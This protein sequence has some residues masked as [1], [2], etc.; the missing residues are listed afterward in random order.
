[1][2]INFPY[3]HILATF[4][5]ATGMACVSAKAP[6]ADTP[7][8]SRLLFSLAGS[9]TIGEHLAPAWVEAFLAAKSATGIYR[10]PMAGANEYR[11]HGT[12]EYEKVH[13]DIRA[14]GSS[15]GFK[16]LKNHS[17]DIAMSSRGIKQDELVSLAALGDL[18]TAA[19]E[20]VVAIDGLAVIV[21]PQN[22]IAALSMDSLA[23][24]FSG[25][26]THW[27]Q[28]GGSDHAISVHARDHNS[29]TWDTFK[30]LVLGENNRLA[31]GAARYESNDELSASVAN[32]VGAIG[33]VGL[34]SVNKSKALAIF[35]GDTD[36]LPPLPLHVATED[37]LLARRLFLY[38]STKPTG[39]VQEF[40]HFCQTHDGQ[41]LVE[42]IGFV[43]QNPLRQVVK[44]T[45]GPAFYREMSRRAERLSINFRFQRNS[46]ELDNKAKRDVQRLAH[47]LKQP[48]NQDLRVQ[49]IGFSDERN[50]SSLAEVLS[51]LRATVVK[52]E[53]F[54]HGIATEAVVGFGA[55]RPVAQASGTKSKNDR[56]EV[57]VYADDQDPALRA[58]RRR[59]ANPDGYLGAQHTLAR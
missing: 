3:F 51:R 53:L 23:L 49:L 6:H 39:L 25:K 12:F 4:I 29:G 33:F 9:N 47:F 35:D 41:E 46:A 26:I 59:T 36:A 20:H 22:P 15:T 28:L 57:W 44:N 38:T 42:E 40:V 54:H 30:T 11:V 8:N 10:E 18:S 37:Y 13:I 56:V 1:M 2:H 24:I 21:H 5:L 16:S 58:L 17:A 31:S 27:H 50:T 43:A 32:D 7:D 55:S 34:A 14:H 48:Q 19:G 52:T 45:A